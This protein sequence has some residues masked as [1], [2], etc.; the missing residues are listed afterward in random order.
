MSKFFSIEYL[1][2][3]VT[4][5]TAL[6]T[7]ITIQE[8]KRQRMASQK[9][10]LT[11]QDLEINILQYYVTENKKFSL[12]FRKDNSNYANHD[13]DIYN[14]GFGVAKDIKM[15]WFVNYEEIIKLIEANEK[16]NK[17]GLKL[18]ENSL[19]IEWENYYRGFFEIQ[20]DLSSY[21][22]FLFPSK[23]LIITLKIPYA[24]LF[25]ST[26]YA[27]SFNLDGKTHVLPHID[28][29]MSYKDI[30]DKIYSKKM[31]LYL[32]INRSIQKINPTKDHNVSLGDFYV[33]ILEIKPIHPLR[34]WVTY[35]KSL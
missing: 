16:F 32:A 19:I 13:L 22:N 4:F 30:S 27:G 31:R 15:D 6:A 26:L 7:F 5:V 25:L 34:K 3:V 8:M 14:I 18:T 21:S 2:L 1:T 23:D 17:Y 35:V 29:E 33:K 11:T 28:F 20:S 10:S 24:Y 12:E 9:P